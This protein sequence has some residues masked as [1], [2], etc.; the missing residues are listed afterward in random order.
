MSTASSNNKE[1]ATPYVPQIKLDRSSPVPLYFQI[2]EPIATLI[3]DGT[4]PAG[5]RSRAPLRARPCS[6]WST[7]DCSRAGAGSAPWSPLPTSTARW[8]SPRC[9]PT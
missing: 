9:C 4:L 6:A 2:S 5:S 8:S 3:N 1:G 7:A